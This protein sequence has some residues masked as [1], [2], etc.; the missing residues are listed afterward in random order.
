MEKM[1]HQ[2]LIGMVLKHFIL[3]YEDVEPTLSIPHRYGT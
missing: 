3:F 2:F 1:K